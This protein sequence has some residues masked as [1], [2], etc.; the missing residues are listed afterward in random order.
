MRLTITGSGVM[1][2]KIGPYKVSASPGV[3]TK[4]QH[5]NG[6]I[7]CLTDCKVKHGREESREVKRWVTSVSNAENGFPIM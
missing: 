4:S 1:Y 6:G 3:E 5:R 7:K 2:H